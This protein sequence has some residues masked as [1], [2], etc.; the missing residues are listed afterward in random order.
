MKKFYVTFDERQKG[1]LTNMDAFAHRLS[2]IE[3]DT[4]DEI[5]ALVYEKIKKSDRRHIRIKPFKIQSIQ[6]YV[7]Q[8]LEN[9]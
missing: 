1:H 3:A 6:E 4:E 9:V 8:E 7:N 5:P 2:V